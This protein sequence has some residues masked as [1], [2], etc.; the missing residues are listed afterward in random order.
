[1]IAHRLSTIK[2]ADCIVVMKDG[3]I[4]EQG[5]HEELLTN[6]NGV[7]HNLVNA[8]QLEIASNEEESA[9]LEDESPEKALLD[10]EDLKVDTASEGD[11]ELET[12][13]YKPRGLVTSV[14]FFLYEQ[15][16]HYFL[17]VL[18]LIGAMI[19][20]GKQALR[21]WLYTLTDC[22]SCVPSSELCLCKDNRGLPVHWTRA[23][24]CW[25]LLVAD[26][27]CNRHLRCNCL[28]LAQLCVESSCYRKL[29][30]SPPNP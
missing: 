30:L 26:V 20:G 21:T 16:R 19:S 8:Q 15:R 29:P 7:Y 17:Y 27:L 11:G 10:P 6:L 9:T 1:M 3:T 23:Y 5:T 12:S 13:G 25:Q 4:V 14:G 22:N 24:R 28:Y 2:K 18:V